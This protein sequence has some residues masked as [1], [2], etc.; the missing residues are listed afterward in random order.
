[1]KGAGK[2]EMHWYEL[3]LVK[4]I[5]IS[6][7]K[8]RKYECHQKNQKLYKAEMPGSIQDAF[9]FFSFQRIKCFNKILFIAVRVKPVSAVI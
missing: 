1:M 7:L 4:V 8:G 2:E 3:P 9:F 5:C 6:T